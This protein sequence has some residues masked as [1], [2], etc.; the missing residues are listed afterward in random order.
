MLE[1][2]AGGGAPVER[3]KW[4]K[5]S[6]RMWLHRGDPVLFNQPWGLWEGGSIS[7]DRQQMTVV[8]RVDREL[9]FDGLFYG[10]EGM[11]VGGKRRL[12]IAP[13]LAYREKGVP[14]IIPANA[15]LTVEVT[16]DEERQMN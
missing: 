13:H 11:S 14:G 16:I 12:E 8:L 3:H 1:D 7:L 2:V 5:V 6:L 9:M 15:L 10:V 4:Y